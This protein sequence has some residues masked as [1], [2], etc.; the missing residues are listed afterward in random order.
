VVVVWALGL[1]DMVEDK[2][3]VNRYMVVDMGN[4]NVDVVLDMVNVDTM[5]MIVAL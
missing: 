1:A 4:M 5:S 3:R 2:D